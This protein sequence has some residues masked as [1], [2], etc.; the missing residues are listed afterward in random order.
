MTKRLGTPLPLAARTR[1]LARLAATVLL[2]ALMALGLACSSES[3]DPNERPVAAID[4]PASAAPGSAIVLDGSASA[5]PEGAPLS[6]QWQ[7]V[8]G[9]GVEIHGLSA[10]SASFAAPPHAE[11]SESV[12]FTLVVSD[13]ELFSAP[14]LVTIALIDPNTPP[15]ADAG[16]A[17]TVAPGDEV[18]LLG[19]G[20]DGDDDELS[21]RW[22][23]VAG[24]YV[25]LTG[26][27]G[28]E[29]V[30]TAPPQATTLAFTLTVSDGA[31]T[32]ETDLVVI[33]VEGP[34]PNGAPLATISGPAEAPY[35]SEVS[36]DGSGSSDPEGDSLSFRWWQV[37]GPGVSVEGLDEQSLRFRAP[38]RPAGTTELEADLEIAFAL[39][40]NDGQLDSAP[41]IFE[42]TLVEDNAAP[43]ADAGEDQE[44]GAD[45]QVTLSGSGDDSDGDDLSYLWSQVAGPYVALS[46]AT[47]AQCTFT[48][49]G[50]DTALAFELVVSDGIYSS[51]PDLVLVTVS[52]PATVFADAGPAQ[53][54]IPGELVTLHGLAGMPPDVDPSYAWTQLSG[55]DVSL[56][57][58]DS[59]TPTFQAPAE[60]GA[61]VFQLVVSGGGGQS[62]PA[63]TTVTVDARPVADAGLD[64]S[65]HSGELVSLDGSASLDPDGGDLSWHWRQ[66]AG[67]PVILDTEAPSA[68][69][70]T[71]P[72]ATS[73]LV[74][75]LTVHD[76][77]HGS[78]ADT[79]V[80]LVR[81][82]QVPVALPGAN[83]SV[84]NGAELAL[85]AAST[86]PENDLIVDW[87][88]TVIGGPGGAVISGDNLSYQLGGDHAA[89]AT[90]RPFL[91]GDWTLTLRVADESGWSAPVAFV[92]HS[93]NNAPVAMAGSNRSLVNG[94]SLALH[95]ASSDAD[96]DAVSYAWSLKGQPEGS[97]YALVNADQADATF[98]PEGK[99][100]WTLTLQVDDGEDLS[101]ADNLVIIATNRAPVVE[102]GADLMVGD[103]T[104]TRLE[105]V[106]SDPDG[107]PLSTSWAILETVPAGL[108]GSF[109][110]A[111]DGGEDASI[112][113]PDAKGTYVI[114]VTVTDD[115]GLDAKDT[116]LVE[117]YMLPDPAA[118]IYLTPTG[119][120]DY[121]GA[122]CGAS[123]QPCL[124]LSAAV[125]EADLAGKDVVMAAGDYTD[126]ARSITVPA[127]VKIYGGFDPLTWARDVKATP[128]ILR[129]APLVA[130]EGEFASDGRDNDCDGFVDEAPCVGDVEVCD[131]VDNDCDG[132]IDNTDVSC[133][134]TLEP[135]DSADAAAA[136][137]FGLR[138]SGLGITATASPDWYLIEVPAL[139]PIDEDWVLAFH[140]KCLT[141]CPTNAQQQ[142]QVELYEGGAEAGDRI[143]YGGTEYQHP[144]YVPVQIDVPKGQATPGTYYLKVETAFPGA[145]GQ[146]ATYQIDVGF[147]AVGVNLT[148][149][150]AYEQVA[151]SCRDAY[152]IGFDGVRPMFAEGDENLLSGLTVYGHVDGIQTDLP[153][154]T[155]SGSVV[156]CDGC[157]MTLE[158]NVF[159]E[160]QVGRR[161]LHDDGQDSSA[162]IA[163]R[164]SAA[165]PVTVERNEL[166]L[167]YTSYAYG[168]DVWNAGNLVVRANRFSSAEAKLDP[169]VGTLGMIRLRLHDRGDDTLVIDQNRF[170][171]EGTAGQSSC[172]SLRVEPSTT[173]H[174]FAPLIVSNNLMLHTGACGSDA[175]VYLS[176]A[177]LGA[178]KHPA[179]LLLN[180][181]FFGN[182]NGTAVQVIDS[183][184]GSEPIAFVNNYFSG[185]QTAMTSGYSYP[186]FGRNVFDSVE[187]CSYT[188]YSSVTCM[189]AT[190]GA[191][192][193]SN[194]GSSS[195][196]LAGSCPVVDAA[197]GDY[198]W[199][200]DDASGEP[201]ASACVDGGLLGG[202]P[203][204]WP[205]IPAWFAH[206]HDGLTRPVDAPGASCPGGATCD[207]T[208]IG[209]YELA[210]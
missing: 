206:D 76:G 189:G 155:K 93:E 51:A 15:V 17:Q 3:S 145:F 38:A 198:H 85:I 113:T 203:D 148:S 110:P 44:V 49:P 171:V 42:L 13:G 128:T 158:D 75:E 33:T 207:D 109:V 71:A 133:G 175:P 127:G 29:A 196:N 138:T 47:S 154:F 112:F 28:A 161:S 210:F 14:A 40:V 30:F 45:A 121:D 80:V 180:N 12:A 167:G 19:T 21:Y 143:W 9:P 141:S 81:H 107:D 170:E 74:F 142:L 105:P 205:Q 192:V 184:H 64:Q 39:V 62:L 8:S 129:G 63:T 185:F 190:C 88:W 23:Q 83:K 95:G 72:E 25:A 124:D 159:I 131:N 176:C 168:I 134:D 84:A 174:V 27:D 194:Y 86:D 56:A 195:G 34:A 149:S 46:D 65:A 73:S 32:S 135:N 156:F 183:H 139:P 111:D 22:Q 119:A 92:V 160:S 193:D 200:L 157:A 181:S 43:S 153:S 31:T 102:L 79:V 78:D 100:V 61:L 82:N 66:L 98:T 166:R 120:N 52:A 137:G 26:A 96:G 186:Y 87:E 117:V 59:A 54:V 191:C 208:D 2:L 151:P 106:A 177:K 67:A 118:H 99:G 10:A 152:V 164:D 4:A 136:L 89:N 36:L 24:P 57:G 188:N 172:Y 101:L 48:A 16:E 146:P 108:T 125:L 162:V 165:Y 37:A 126:R 55:V 104:E 60:S 77:V 103:L 122:P 5:D 50:A 201:A 94:S 90:F 163:V 53:L 150:E 209:A 187:R 130:E 179:T 204:G 1:P 123:D 41:A 199:A 18:T 20:S 58:A 115:D 91:K 169:E 6:F 11:N 202:I 68:P 35:R 97:S 178:S 147:K 144:T 70:F 7:Q 116:I 173:G 114:E 182:G 69:S 132:L 197:G 140:L